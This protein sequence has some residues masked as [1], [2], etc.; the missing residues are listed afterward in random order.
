[1]KPVFTSNEIAH[2]WAHKSAPRGKSPGAMSFDG[3]CF[4]S[5]STVIARHIG[6]RGLAAVVVNENQFSNTTAKH[7]SHVRR[8]LNGLNIPVFYTSEGYNARLV[9][10]GRE[11]FDYA[12]EKSTDFQKQAGKAR[13]RKAHLENIAAG[14]LERAK[15]INAFFGLRRKVDKKTIERLRAASEKAERE[16]EVKRLAKEARDRIDQQLAFD[17][18]LHNEPCEYFNPSLFPVS[19]RIENMYDGV[20]DG[21]RELVSTLGA[22]VPLYEA[23]IAL[24]FVLAHRESGWTRNGET[25]RVGHY[26]LD[27]ITSA[28]VKAG[29]HNITWAEIDRLAS[30]LNS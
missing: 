3:D 1:M 8:A 29:C 27:S 30:V 10:T 12:V 22:R 9:V 14:W 15:E 20:K 24:R 26:Q 25:H 21:K 28:G 5:Y 17:H 18:W 7:H 4:Y 2:V 11:L 13:Q 23:R 19:F 16:A 6:H